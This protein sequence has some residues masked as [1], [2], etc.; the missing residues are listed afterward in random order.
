MKRS[1]ITYECIRLKNANDTKKKLATSLVS[2][3]YVSTRRR[4]SVWESNSW[5]QLEL[6]LG[7]PARS[8]SHSLRSTS[9]P[10]Q[11]HLRSTS[12]PAELTANDPSLTNGAISRLVSQV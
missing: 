4:R 11:I 5:F 2:I 9:N 10:P 8:T 6:G 7:F 1:L 12:D 3:R